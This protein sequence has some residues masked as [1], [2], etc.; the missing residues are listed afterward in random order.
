MSGLPYSLERSLLIC[1]QRKT[2]FRFFTESQ[3]FA[4]W[5]GVGSHIDG[6]PGGSLKI[7]YPDGTVALGEVVEMVANER[8]VFTYGYESASK[9]IPPGGSR[10]TITLQERSDGTWLTL[11]HDVADEKTRDQHVPGWRYQLALFANA[12]A[13]TQHGDLRRLLDRYFAAW[14][15]KDAVARRREFT[16]IALPGIVFQDR[17]GCTA[18]LDDLDA[19]VALSQ[20]HMRDVSLHRAGEPRQCQGTALVEWEAR[21]SDGNRLGTG[22]NIFTL[23]PDGRI[24]RVVGLWSAPSQP[25]RG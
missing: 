19:H 6:R 3:L 16:E 18:G 21:G 10:V 17:F 22:S 8:I 5:W 4:E 25:P 14:A 11:K 2:V 23:A 13:G 20:M 7:V 9:P 1:A 15:E 24:A 12:A